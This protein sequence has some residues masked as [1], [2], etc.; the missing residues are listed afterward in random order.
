MNKR[1]MKA[2]R[3]AMVVSGLAMAGGIGLAEVGAALAAAP[4]T[5]TEPAGENF[6]IHP[7][8]DQSFCFTDVPVPDLN[9]ETSMQQCSTID[10]DHW[11]FAQSVDGSSVLVDD[12]GLCL[13]A[14]K[15]PNKS[16]QVNPCTFLTPEHFFYTAK[17]QIR[18]ESGNLCLEA[19]QVATSAAVTFNTCVK[20]LTTQVWVLGH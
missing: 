5:H 3:V 1:G 19:T 10:S 2:R 13:E 20:G 15:K 7:S 14:A 16:A 8:A 11:A 4:A 9:R 17:G 18:S 12:N 6:T